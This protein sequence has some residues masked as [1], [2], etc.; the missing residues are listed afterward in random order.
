[1]ALQKINTQTQK[2]QQSTKLKTKV[3]KELGTSISS[4]Y[5]DIIQRATAKPETLTPLE[6]M[7]LHQTIGNRAVARILGGEKQ[8]KTTESKNVSPKIKLPANLRDQFI[9]RIEDEKEDKT[10]NCIKG[11]VREIQQRMVNIVEEMAEK[12]EPIRKVLDVLARCHIYIKEIAVFS[13]QNVP[14]IKV[15]VLRLKRVD[16]DKRLSPNINRSLTHYFTGKEIKD[17]SWKYHDVVEADGKIFDVESADQGKVGIS[18]YILEMF[19]EQE[20]EFEEVDIKK[21]GEADLGISVGEIRDI[22]LDPDLDI[23]DLDDEL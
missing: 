7:Q 21:E 18:E 12:E 16:G 14:E 6:I 20:V 2:V 11:K 1:M 17:L 4:H 5:V 10:V 8:Q 19:P 22:L 13:R 15:R 3:S 9:Q 23:P